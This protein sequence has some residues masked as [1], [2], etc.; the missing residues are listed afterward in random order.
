MDAPRDVT[1]AFGLLCIGI[2]IIA[3]IV[4]Y[5][6]TALVSAIVKRTKW[7]KAVKY[8]WL[9]Y[10]WLMLIPCWLYVYGLSGT[11]FP[12]ISLCWSVITLIVLFTMIMKKCRKLMKFL[13]V[14]ILLVWCCVSFQNGKDIVVEYYDGTYYPSIWYTAYTFKWWCCEI[15]TCIMIT[16]LTWGATICIYK[17]C[18]AIFGHKKKTKTV[19]VSMERVK[20]DDDE[21]GEIAHTKL[22]NTLINNQ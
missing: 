15:S 17:M 10:Q 21:I 11:D 8:L 18:Y 4:T 2:L 16:M 22:D 7:K 6:I 5:L 9:A 20:R 3:I 13:A 14:P 19:E 1:L 12:I